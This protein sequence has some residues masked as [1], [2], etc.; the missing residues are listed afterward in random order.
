MRAVV[1]SAVISAVL[2]LST[3]QANAKDDAALDAPP[4]NLAPTTVHLS[5]ILAAHDAAVGQPVGP[6]TVI[7]DW[8]YTDSGMSGT[9]HLERSGTDYHSIVT[10]GPFTEEYGQLSGKRWH[11]DYNGFVSPTTD[12]DSVT[13]FAERVN[14]DAADPK[15]DAS[16]AGI[17]Q[18]SDPAYVVKVTVSSAKHPEWI[19]YDVK[20]SLI[21]RVEWIVGDHRIVSLYDDFRTTGG[22][23]DAWHVHDDWDPP[24]LDDDYVR[25][26]M[27]TGIAIDAAQFAQP[28][29]APHAPYSEV[30]MQIPA[31]MYDDGTII[32][33][34]VVNGRG[35]DM[36][37][38]TSVA[39]NIID[40]D[41][42]H[43]M[44]L[45]TYG[46]VD[47]LPG[48]GEQAF[49]TLLPQATVGPLVFNNL[50]IEAMPFNFQWSSNIKV[51]GVL[52]YDFLAN[53]VVKIDYYNG[54]IDVMPSFQFNAGDPIQGGDSYPLDFDDGIPFFTMGV[55]DV[56]SDDVLLANE[57]V[58]SEFFDSFVSA[59]PDV[60]VG[61]KDDVDQ[62]D[63]PFANNGS[64]GQ[65]VEQWR[66]KPQDVHFGLV[67]FQQPNVLASN[68]PLY[69]TEDRPVDAAL[70]F[71]FLKFF[72]VYLDYPHDRFIVKP[73]ALFFKM[74]HGSH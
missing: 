44:H 1:A 18:G 65:R 13:F 51:V 24:Q 20:S 37:L 3:I 21:R 70:G 54:R 30:T 62:Q 33:R 6:D 34:M 42:A 7:E 22:V 32:I 36:L 38:D 11:R 59:H 74:I 68:Y 10:R 39:Q 31:Q 55:G 45:P 15:N 64:F 27:R 47:S 19:F 49:E 58:R 16:V 28:P 67:D 63:L 23:T 25:T 26:S 4:P 56:T 60:F 29:S 72:D 53:N 57:I 61:S 8:R 14:D 71:D 73:N 40:E 41:V 69:L 52:G 5:A 2:L 9:V 50:A 46:Q 66:A 35:L 43:Q 12:T 17:T 48:L